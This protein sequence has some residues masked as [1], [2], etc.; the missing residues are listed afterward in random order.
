MTM[1]TNNT[2]SFTDLR[3][4]MW[5]KFRRWLKRLLSN[6]ADKINRTKVGNLFIFIVLALFGAFSLLP[7]VLQVSNSLKPMNEFFLFPPPLFP[8]APTFKNFTDLFA[9]MST[10]W[11]PF[12]RYLFNTVFITLVGTVGTILIGSFAAYPLAKHSKMPG[13]A[14]I[15]TMIT[16][17]LMYNPVVADVA[18]YITMTALGW[19]D[20]Y[21]AVIIPAFGSTLGVFLMRQ[22]MTQVPDSL[23]E[24]AKIDGANEYK[25]Y[26]SIIMPNVKSGWLTMAVFSFNGLWNTTASTFIYREELKTLPYALGQIVAGGLVRQGPA[27]AVGV[28]MMVVPIVFF[29]ITQSRILETMASSGL[30]E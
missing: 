13:R 24:A 19:L 12:S 15:F 26:W 22:F 30:K 18:N 11:V 1:A 5:K 29:I 8:R 23:I 21:L 27:A 16:L 3:T 28:V 10:T 9:L 6:R 20:T 4:A 25:I 14:F 7:M 2:S 17:S